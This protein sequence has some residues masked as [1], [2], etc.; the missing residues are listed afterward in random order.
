MVAKIWIEKEKH[1]LYCSY[2]L[3][4]INNHPINGGRLFFDI[5]EDRNKAD[6]SYAQSTRLDDQEIIQI[7]VQNL[8]FGSLK[9]NNRELSINTYH[10]KPKNVFAIEGGNRGINDFFD[11]K[12]FAF[13]WLET[14][15]FHISRYEEFHFD[16]T[17]RNQWEMMPEKDQIL[18]KH[19]LHHTPVVDELVN[20]ILV[21]LGH[22]SSVVKS[23][24][25][26]SHDIDY[27]SRKKGFQNKFRQFLSFV[28]Y[29]SSIKSA[30][31]HAFTKE[32]QDYH[33]FSF[34]ETGDI[35]IAKRIY[36]HVGGDHVFD[37]EKMDERQ[38]LIQKLASEALSKGYEIG[39]HP[40]YLAAEDPVLFLK[41]KSF[42]EKLIGQKIELSRQHYLHFDFE[43]TLDILEQNGIQEDSSLG[44]NEHVGFRCGTGFNYFLFNWK[45]K[46]KSTVKEQP[47]IWMD[48][49]QRYEVGK[50]SSLFYLKAIK[51]FES[52]KIGTQL[53]INIHNHYWTDYKLYGIDLSQYLKEIKRK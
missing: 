31:K 32:Q 49:A 44:Y 22:P 36:F 7:P 53:N 21:A 52:N 41:E 26:L 18:V 24:W 6:L 25:S 23:N 34:L 1:N 42:L 50:Q 5:T 15:F 35:P 19:K 4:F 47:L 20:A 8:F 13:D 37:P 2:V 46:A 10:A 11:G 28:K 14:I 33:D 39:L 48:S 40:S 45:L 51:F 43:K 29:G 16:P 9:V 27:L 30:F 3:D 12:M 17:L 38:E